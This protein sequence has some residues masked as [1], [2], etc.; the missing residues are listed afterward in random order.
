M[1]PTSQ[2][3]LH[4]LSHSHH[5]K[6]F[7]IILFT[8]A[9][10]STSMTCFLVFCLIRFGS[11]TTACRLV[12][13]LNITTLFVEVS[14][15]PVV[16]V[17]DESTCRA[18]GFFRIYAS[19]SNAVVGLLLVVQS[20]RVIM[21]PRTH[22]DTNQWIWPLITFGFPLVTLLP[23]VTG[24]FGV[25]GPGPQHLFCVFKDNGSSEY[26]SIG[27]YYIWLIIISITI[28][29]FVVKL[30]Y[31]LR[32][33]TSKKSKVARS[34]C[35]YSFISVSCWFP[36]SFEVV[37]LINSNLKKENALWSEVSIFFVYVLGI[38]D[39][40]YFFSEY[41]ILRVLNSVSTREHLVSTET[42]GAHL[43]LYA[44]G[45]DD[46]SVVMPST[47]TTMLLSPLRGDEYR[48]RDSSVGV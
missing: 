41:N 34:L 12:L 48:S 43:N 16:Y 27:V 7:L 18:M 17:N 11:K 44:F 36:R 15:L 8:V 45:D 3:S 39:F 38:L 33:D 32:V 25:Y 9:A 13:L 29:T 6:T 37:S 14:S 2:P 26:W 40:I 4:E 21:A 47:L 5:S 28:F 22:R 19:L 10:I 24:D 20:Y 35:I 1:E 31:E 46:D 30:R 42:P 23:F